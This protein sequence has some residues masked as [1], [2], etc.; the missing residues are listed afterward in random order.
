MEVKDFIQEYQLTG[1]EESFNWVYARYSEKVFNYA[2][3]Q[4]RLRGLTWQDIESEANHVFYQCMCTYKNEIGEFEPYLFIMLRYHIANVSSK[5]KTY[6]AYV[7]RY[8]DQVPTITDNEPEIKAIKKEQRQLLDDLTAKA[9][10][11]SRQAL[12]AFAKSYSFREAAKQLGTSDKTVKNRIRKI[13]TGRRKLSLTDY[14]T[15]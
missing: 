9:T 15:A 3:K 2:R 13:A 14:L 10:I 6:Q 5:A 1:C 11:A 12:V 8:V 7:K 4:T